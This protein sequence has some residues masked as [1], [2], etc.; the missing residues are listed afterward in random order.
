M[1]TKSLRKWSS[2]YGIYGRCEITEKLQ[3]KKIKIVTNFCKCG[4]NL[5]QYFGLCLSS[6]PRLLF[7]QRASWEEL[8]AVGEFL[9]EQRDALQLLP[10]GQVSVRRGSCVA[11]LE[12]V[13]RIRQEK[14]KTNCNT[15]HIYSTFQGLHSYSTVI[16]RN[17]N[18]AIVGFASRDHANRRNFIKCL[19][20]V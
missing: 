3:A 2:N 11:D 6:D 1:F 15:T 8:G 20:I 19:L 17:L 10:R 18:S 5:H 14:L 7:R 9:N 16:S 4:R 12:E 13:V